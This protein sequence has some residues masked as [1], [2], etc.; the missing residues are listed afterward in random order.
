MDYSQIARRGQWP[1]GVHRVFPY[2]ATCGRELHAWAATI[3]DWLEGYW[4]GAIMEMALR[5]AVQ[6]FLA[7]LEARFG[8]GETSAM[9][10]GSLEDWPLPQQGQLFAL[11]G[12]VRG[13]IGVELTESYLMVPVKSVSGLRFPTEVRYENCQLC[14][15]QGCPGRRA[16]YDAGLYER[17]Y[18]KH[19]GQG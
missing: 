3:D 10:P 6:A 11:L 2:V 7:D 8:P 13:A 18:T 9:N 5:T 1:V 4:A 16:P 14:P 17:K 12:D 19:S 15:R